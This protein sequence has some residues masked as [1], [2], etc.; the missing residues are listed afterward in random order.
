MTCVYI[1][2]LIF[3]VHR[4]C[5][6]SGAKYFINLLY[7]FSYFMHKHNN[8]ITI[9]VKFQTVILVITRNKLGKSMHMC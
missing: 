1:D 4:T 3:R 2:F 5:R 6:K 9:E 8:L 7:S